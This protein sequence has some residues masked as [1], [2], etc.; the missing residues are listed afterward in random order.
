[1]AKWV[2]VLLLC[3]AFFSPAIIGASALTAKALPTHININSPQSSLAERQNIH[4]L[5]KQLNTIHSR[6]AI[7]QLRALPPGDIPILLQELATKGLSDAS[8]S[9]LT[10]TIAR[11]RQRAI[12]QTRRHKRYRWYITQ[13]LDAYRRVGDHNPKWDKIAEKSLLLFSKQES[14]PAFD[15]RNAWCSRGLNRLRIR[16]DYAAIQA[17]HAGCHD[18]LITLI[19]DRNPF[20]KKNYRLWP[21]HANIKADIQALL[22]SSYPA[23]IK[24]E[25][26]TAAAN[27]YEAASDWK[28]AAAC[29]RDNLNLLPQIIR[30]PGIPLSFLVSEI[31][32]NIKA[33]AGPSGHTHAWSQANSEIF[34][35]IKVKA[36]TRKIQYVYLFLKG[37]SYTLWAWRA[38]GDQWASQV[39]QNGWKLFD[40][41]LMTADTAL[42]KAYQIFPQQPEAPLELMTVCLGLSHQKQLVEWF[43]RT[44]RADPDNY[45]AC[46]AMLWALHRRWFGSTASMKT[47]GQWCL[48]YGHWKS[49]IPFIALHALFTI[50][51]N[52]RIPWYDNDSNITFII[53]GHHFWRYPTVWSTVHAIYSGY[54]RHCPTS[55]YHL[56]LYVFMCMWAD[57]WGPIRSHLASYLSAERSDSQMET[58]VEQYYFRGITPSGHAPLAVLVGQNALPSYFNFTKYSLNQIYNEAKLRLAHPDTAKS[59]PF[60]RASRDARYTKWANT[61]TFQAIP[62]HADK[63][64]RWISDAKQAMVEEARV[65]ARPADY[66]GNERDLMI[67]TAQTAITEGC[68]NPLLL[69][70]KAYNAIAITGSNPSA[71]KQEL[72]AA[73]VLLMSHYPV[74]DQFPAAV[75]AASA[76]EALR[77]PNRNIAE[78]M[79]AGARRLLPEFAGDQGIPVAIRFAECRKLWLAA[80]VYEKSLKKTEN[81]LEP[82]LVTGHAP[83]RLIALVKAW[84]EKKVALDLLGGTGLSAIRGLPP[85]KAAVFLSDMHK[86]LVDYHLAW[87]LDPDCAIATN[88]A[89]TAQFWIK[90]RTGRPWWIWPGESKWFIRSFNANPDNL[91]ACLIALRFEALCADPFDGESYG[92]NN[93]YIYQLLRNTMYYRKPSNPMALILL[94]GAQIILDNPATNAAP[95]QAHRVTLLHSMN[96]WKHI[97]ITMTA[98]FKAHPQDEMVRSCYAHLAC[99]L[100]HWNTAESQFLLLGNHSRVMVFGGAKMYRKLKAQ[101]ARA[102][103]Q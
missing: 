8:R 33:L 87:T 88:G 95:H 35:A 61:A 58:T 46:D 39:T 34:K 97:N 70:F 3:F 52:R 71:I 49:R 19:V 91:A 13:T 81:I 84:Y 73:Q 14:R 45:S 18:P 37:F 26:L 78:N 53:V 32:W 16:T 4:R 96:I 83:P 57:K 79:L 98:Y 5:V 50:E 12:T 1:M 6:N 17:I 60:R 9:V 41:R 29:A 100:H 40:K 77:S 43:K 47:F 48:N 25:F 80:N 38:R 94:Y 2:S 69:Y 82:L 59:W 21:F 67:S 30:Q 89:M 24:L 23:A 63:G 36:P 55:A 86:S 76:A 92:L 102:A 20:W 44:M 101:A 22:K 103:T 74:A 27:R 15:Y 54:Y 93:E 72:A 56:G 42:K 31:P 62:P 28:S 85:A 90:V 7:Q 99:E 51:A 75:S 68:K 65:L 64:F 10:E 11:V 66:R